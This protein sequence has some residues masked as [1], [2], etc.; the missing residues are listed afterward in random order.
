M[1]LTVTQLGAG[2]STTTPGASNTVDNSGGSFTFTSGKWYICA[3]AQGTGSTSL[4][5]PTLSGAT[6]GSWTRR[7][8]SSFDTVASST[9]RLNWFHVKATSTFSE[10][11]T[12]AWA[13]NTPT[14]VAVVICESNS[15]PA[16][17]F[18]VQGQ[19]GNGD[20]GTTAS[21]TTP[22]SAFA[23]A[24]NGT[25]LV[26]GTTAT[27]AITAGTGVDQVAFKTE[28]APN[29]AVWVG[30]RAGETSSPTATFASANWGCLA[31]ELTKDAATGTWGPSL[32]DRLNRLVIA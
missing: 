9:D 1:T 29:I 10:T 8:P 2:W 27:G 19:S 30:F 4:T 13:A 17:T 21:N 20:T 24:N 32:S 22:L 12:L 15:D 28:T 5:N 16:G 11:L 6:S 31:A 3:V 23:N 18:F 25:L 26:V 7:G 14:S